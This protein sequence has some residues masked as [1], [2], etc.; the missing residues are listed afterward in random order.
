ML[1]GVEFVYEKTENFN[2]FSK[3]IMFFALVN[4]K[5]F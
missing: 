1:Q 3:K 4:E 5:K 2:D